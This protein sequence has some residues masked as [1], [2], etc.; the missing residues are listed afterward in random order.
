MTEPECRS[1]NWYDYGWRDALGGLRPMYEVYAHQCDALK[2][3]A[4]EGDYMKGWHE[5]KW[6]YDHRVHSSDCCGP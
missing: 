4:N 6:E 1:A 5:G 2:V 3:K